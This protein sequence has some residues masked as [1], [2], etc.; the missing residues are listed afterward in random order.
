MKKIMLGVIALSL[1]FVAVETSAKSFS[2]RSSSSFRSSSSSSFKSYKPSSSYSYKS[3]NSSSSY[4]APKSKPSESASSSYSQK[5][6]S[7]NS[8]R[9]VDNHQSQTVPA[10]VLI[11]KPGMTTGQKVALGAAAVGT[12]VVAHEAFAGTHEAAVVSTEHVQSTTPASHEAEHTD[13]AKSTVSP[14]TN[15]TSPAKPVTMS[16]NQ[17]GY[18]TTYHHPQPKPRPVVRNNNSW[19]NYYLLRSIQRPARPYYAYNSH[20]AY[21]MSYLTT[22]DWER[23]R[24]ATQRY[25]SQ[26]ATVQTF[27]SKAKAEC[28]G[29]I[30][31]CDAMD[32]ADFIYDAAFYKGFSEALGASAAKYGIPDLHASVYN[33]YMRDFN[34]HKYML[35]QISD[36]IKGDEVLASLIKQAYFTGY[37]AGLY[38][39]KNRL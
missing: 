34:G 35:N 29:Q 15:S 14:T 1:A 17:Q 7:T 9:P 6:A 12:G 37:S 26:F 22:N 31:L 11:K 28:T 3:S 5:P 10:P 2:S 18:T 20:Y 8:Y 30:Y 33:T 38:T 4:S 23:T 27:E 24:E 19:M 13:S 16:A 36:T 25:V 39:A 32:N 21:R